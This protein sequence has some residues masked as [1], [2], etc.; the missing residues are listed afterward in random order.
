VTIEIIRGYG[1]EEWGYM[2]E[3]KERRWGAKT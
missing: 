3:V 2:G 1:F